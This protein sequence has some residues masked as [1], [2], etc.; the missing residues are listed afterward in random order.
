M[1]TI[2]NSS[3]MAHTTMQYSVD[4]KGLKW[5]VV[6]EQTNEPSVHWKVELCVK[7]MK[8]VLQQHKEK[9]E[10]ALRVE[11]E[12][13]LQ[14]IDAEINETKQKLEVFHNV[15]GAIYEKCTK[16]LKR[17]ADTV[18]TEISEVS[19]LHEQIFKEATQVLD[20]AKLKT[21]RE[22]KCEA[23]KMLKAAK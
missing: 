17:I 18:T 16:R 9:V 3:R 4:K 15:N 12:S 8:V 6:E 13:L 23:E 20:K 22:F 1:A 5:D 14:S 2:R 19:T 7:E 10:E 21:I 11:Y